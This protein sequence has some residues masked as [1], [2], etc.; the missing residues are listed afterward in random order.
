[1]SIGKLL[2]SVFPRQ[3]VDTCVYAHVHRQL[4]IRGQKVQICV[5]EGVRQSWMR[6]ATSS[7][8]QVPRAWAAM[9]Q[10]SSRASRERRLSLRLYPRENYGRTG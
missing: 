3:P 5:L 4:D 1:M 2:G 8:T 9:V 10:S 7:T 6:W